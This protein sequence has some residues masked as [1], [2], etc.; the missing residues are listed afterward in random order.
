[1]KFTYEPETRP[2]DGFTIKR[3]IDR[4]GF[5]EVY[6]ALS[7]SGKEV[8]LKLLQRN[9][10]V[11]LRGIAHCLNLKHPNLVTLFD[12][13]HDVDGGQWLVMEYVGGRSMDQ[14]LANAPQGMAPAEIEK[15]LTQMCAGVAYLHDK[16]VVHRDLKPANIFLENGIVKIGD[17][18]LAKSMTPSQ[19]SAHTES[20]GTVYYMAPEVSKGKYGHEIDVYSLGV[21]LYE[22]LTGHVP[23]SGE[24]AGEI[25]MKHLTEKPDLTKVPTAYRP[26]VAR[27]LQKDPMLRTPSAAQ[28]AKEFGDA[29]HGRVAAHDLSAKDFLPHGRNR[30]PAAYVLT[31][32]DLLPRNGSAKPKSNPFAHTSLEPPAPFPP[33]V[34]SKHAGDATP[35]TLLKWGGLIV[36]ALTVLYVVRMGRGGAPVGAMVA[37]GGLVFAFGWALLAFVNGLSQA[38]RVPAARRSNDR[39]T[40]RISPFASSPETPRRLTFLQRVEDVTASM[41]KATIWSI[42]AAVILAFTAGL[43][44]Q[45]EKMGLFTL[46]TIL[47]SWAVLLPTKLMWEGSNTPTAARRFVLGALGACVGACGFWVHQSLLVETM[48]VRNNGFPGIFQEVGLQPLVTSTQEPTLAGFVIFFAALFALRRWWWRADAFRSSQF[49][50]GSVLLTMLLGFLLPAVFA[51]PQDWA[52]AWAGAISTV[53]QLSAGF[54]PVKRRV[55]LLGGN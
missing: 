2:L 10:D 24:S 38:S 42:T 34:L 1:M 55:P 16:G 12:V 40:G 41:T 7:D 47:G 27:A 21:M 4:G 35:A 37:A 45:P 8:A 36:A 31:E 17:V 53:V 5:G 23:F 32:K 6:Y 50:L 44:D 9:A 30:K 25:L 20:V 29:L 22:M 54:T 11:E 3:A 43:T 14:A 49:S 28:L 39:S 52:V 15:W 33:R 19:R 18:G 26:V 13:K 48:T 51:F 46:T